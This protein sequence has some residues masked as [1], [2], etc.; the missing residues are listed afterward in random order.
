MNIVVVDERGGNYT[1]PEETQVL[2]PPDT[3][4]EVTEELLAKNEQELYDENF[5]YGHL[6]DQSLGK[7]VFTRRTD[8]KTGKKYWWPVIIADPKK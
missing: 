6:K 3:M 7:M 1:L 5:T 2:I 4:E 8:Q